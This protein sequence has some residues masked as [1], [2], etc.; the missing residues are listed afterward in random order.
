MNYKKQLKNI[1]K[2]KNIFLLIIFLLSFVYFF[3]FL[4]DYFLNKKFSLGKPLL[5]YHHPNFGYALRPNQEITRFGKKIKVDKYGSRSNF[6]DNDQSK[7][8]FYGDSVV[9]GGRIVNNSELFSELTCENL[10]KRNSCL[11]F[12]TNAYGLENVTRRIDQDINNYKNDFLIIFFNFS[13]LKRGVSK[14]SGQPFFNKPIDGKFK[15]IREVFLRYLDIERLKYRYTQ[16]NKLDWEEYDKYLFDKNG[17]IKKSL[18][19]YYTSVLDNLYNL[20][21][22]RYNDY[23]IVINFA[24][25]NKNEKNELI[26]LIDLMKKFDNKKILVLRDLFEK[27][28]INISKIFYDH[29]H[30]NEYGHKVTAN[31]I[32]KYLKE[33]YEKFN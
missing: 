29:I 14:I 26:Q 10:E 23:L 8:I 2:L 32:S 19:S 25:K 9:Y 3:L 5:Y 6:V 27:N 20:V 16:T 18:L 11:N 17:K 1:I 15:A 7:I 28:D 31:I 33:N 21:N 12:G 24:E 30:F 13:N 22:Y 4:V